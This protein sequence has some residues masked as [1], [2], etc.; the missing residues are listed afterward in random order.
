MVRDSN[1]AKH[2]SISGV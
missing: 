2:N 1:F